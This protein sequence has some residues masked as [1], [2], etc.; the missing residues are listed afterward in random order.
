MQKEFLHFER[1]RFL[2]TGP[3]TLLSAAAILLLF[4]R[5]APATSI[6]AYAGQPGVRSTDTAPGKSVWQVSPPGTAGVSAASLTWVAGV[7]T[8]DGQSSPNPAQTFGPQNY[9]G[10]GGAP[11][12]NFVNM[13]EVYGAAP[14]SLAINKGSGSSS[15]VPILNPNGTFLRTDYI[16]NWTITA[17]GSLG[18]LRS[19]SW[20]SHT[21][22]NDPWS[23][24]ASD[25]AGYSISTYDLFFAAGIT[26]ADLSSGGS[27]GFDVSYQ[28]AS[29]TS[30]LLNVSGGLGG[31]NVSMGS[32][33]GLQI[34]AMANQTDGPEDLTGA[35]LTAG[36]IQALF[37]SAADTGILASPVE[38]GFLLSGQT[39]P[40]QDMGGGAVA[41]LNASTSVD[42]QASGSSTAAPEPG[43]F[44]LIGSGLVGIAVWGRWRRAMR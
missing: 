33:P 9:F 24:T 11:V 32:I 44:A 13:Y 2:S 27:F 38:F 7:D 43:A 22:A 26:S 20:S 35:P 34:Y 28:T 37:R 41:W 14:G 17:T 18:N 15:A 12:P 16:A 30:D 21:G 10:P 42:D 40:T 8:E 5:T 25:F 1:G 23:L 31:V 3:S 36:L 39:I 6:T 29:G 4:A 19:S